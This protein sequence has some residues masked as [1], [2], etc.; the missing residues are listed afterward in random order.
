MATEIIF[1]EE[2]SRDVFDKAKNQMVKMK[3]LRLN[4]NDDYN[5]GM[6]GADIA[7]QIRGS[8]CF[9]HW[10]R[11]FKWWHSTFWWGVQVLMVNAYK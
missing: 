9:D 4:V 2:K 3:F 7:D 8:Y 5:F 6:G 1:W 11:N 10:V